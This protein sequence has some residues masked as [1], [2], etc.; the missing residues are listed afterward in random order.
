MATK[1]WLG[2]GSA[3]LFNVAGNWTPSGVPGA[4]DVALFNDKANNRNCNFNI[5]TGSSLTIGEIIVES[6]YGG[7]VLLQTVPVT[8]GIFLGKVEGI[9]A[10]TVSTIDFRQGGSGSEYGSYKSFANRFL[11]IDDVGSWGAGITLNMYGGSV[12]TKFDDGDHA[13]T[14]LKTG[15]FAPNYVAPT[16][17]SGKTTFTAFTADDGITF[18]PTGNLVDNDRLKHF[19]F[20]SFTYSDDLFNAG[21]AT[22]EFKAT[23]SGIYFPITGATGYGQSPST[24]PS[25]FVSYM[26]KVILTA[27]TAGHKILFNDNNYISLEEL[28]IGDGVMLLGP[29]ALTAQGADIRLVN[30]PKI[31]GSWSFSQISQGVYRSPRHASGPMP[32]IAGNFHITGKLDVDGLIDPTGLELT[33]VG[34]N[35]GGVTANT[36]WLNSGQSNKLYH[37]SSEVGGGGSGDITGVTITTDSGGGSKAEDTGGSAD[38]SILGAT[39]VGVTNSG[40][41]ITAVAVPAEIDHD[42]LQN[43]V[44]AEHVDWAGASAGTIHASNYTDTNT[45]LSNAEVRTAVEA[46]TDSNVFTDAD[47]TKLNGIEASA[48]VTDSRI[49]QSTEFSD[50]NAIGWWTFAVIKGRDAAGNGQRGQ[51]QFYIQETDSSRHRTCR[52]EVGHH[53]GR[54]G[55]NFINLLGVSAYGNEL[56]FTDFRIKEGTTYDGAALQIYISNATNDLKG[57]MM[58]NLGV[59]GGWTLLDTILA[60]SDTSG[61][62]SILGYAAGGFANFADSFSVGKTLDIEETGIVDANDGGGIAT[63]GGL[64]VDGAARITGN[65]TAG[66]TVDGRDLAT[67]G[68]KLDGI[69]ASADVTDATNVTAAGALMDSECTNLAAVKAYD[70]IFCRWGDIGGDHTDNKATNI[71]VDNWTYSEGSTALRDAMSSGVFTCTAALAGTY[72]IVSHLMYKTG[73]LGEA[74]GRLFQIQNNLYYNAGGGT[75]SSGTLRGFTRH[76]NNDRYSDT[77]IEGNYLLTLADGDTFGIYGKI[78]CSTSGTVKISSV[79]TFTNLHMVKIA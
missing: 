15:S 5:T 25:A 22:C 26:R 2:D 44:A 46:A 13:T 10:D 57:H 54:D 21:A 32:K 17:T 19:D 27:D 40:T 72:L 51:A 68:S 76:I 41:T 43:F 29:T 63:T 56:S 65:I 42:S 71:L 31:R 33:P 37:G 23:S 1:E 70:P 24:T 34:S 20:G 30:A 4:G 35:P 73:T 18:Q 12:V 60:D 52:I 45:Q 58:M 64:A 79:N 75:P 3:N 36:L 67:D 7:T 9:K 48:D 49:L 16:G 47:H 69:E 78:G 14:V 55:S 59:S 6:T 39:G 77:V 11:M 38:F 74:N 53:F 62:N 50:D 8:K 28:E 61:H 66:G